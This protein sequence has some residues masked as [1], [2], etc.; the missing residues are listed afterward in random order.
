MEAQGDAAPT[1]GRSAS[2]LAKVGS[3]DVQPIHRNPFQ[4]HYSGQRS[5]RGHA[6]D[7]PGTTGVGD[8]VD[9]G[10]RVEQEP[11]HAVGDKNDE[12]EPRG[13]GHDGVGL[14][15]GASSSV[16]K[17]FGLTIMRERAARLNGTL[18]IESRPAGGT[19]IRLT[20]PAHLPRRPGGA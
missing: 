5:G 9:P 3:P 13:R 10:V 8:P 6:G 19:I 16:G 20:F 17:S 18:S 14:P 4:S 12:R 15:G 11:R 2:C 1:H 7:Q